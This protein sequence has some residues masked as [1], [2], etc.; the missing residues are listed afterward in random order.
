M[1]AIANM[2]G[3]NRIISVDINKVIFIKSNVNNLK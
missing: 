2:T 3:I 1:L